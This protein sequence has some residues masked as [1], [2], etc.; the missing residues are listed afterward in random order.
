M[1]SLNIDDSNKGILLAKIVMNRYILNQN[2][3]RLT[4]NK[5]K[6]TVLIQEQDILLYFKSQ[7]YHLGFDR[8]N[9][10]LNLGGIEQ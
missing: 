8:R 5:K 7:L 4:D 2:K 9:D 10:N 1:K 3:L 6:R